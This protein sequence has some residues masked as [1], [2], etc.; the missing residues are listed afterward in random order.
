MARIQT[1]NR[2]SEF[3]GRSAGRA[4]RRLRAIRRF[5]FVPELRYTRAVFP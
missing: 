4:N 3:S 1:V 5:S 2:F